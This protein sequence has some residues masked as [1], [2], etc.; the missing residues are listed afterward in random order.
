[1]LLRLAGLNRWMNHDLIRRDVAC[2]VFSQP[3]RRSKLRLY[4]SS[5]NRLQFLAWLEAHGLARRNGNLGSSARVAT[6]AGLAR[7]HIEHAESA[8]LNPIAAGQRI[9]H[10]L[11]DGFHGQLGLGLGD[12]SPGDHFVD[13][14]ELDHE[15]LPRAV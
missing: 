6:D 14:V 10:A 8:Q 3:A 7:A 4:T 11:K 2:N 15:R 9:L 1:M 5:I 13:N 12:A